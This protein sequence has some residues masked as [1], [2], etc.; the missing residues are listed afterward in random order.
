MGVNDRLLEKLMTTVD[1]LSKSIKTLEQKIEWLENQLSEKLDVVQNG[2][3]SVSE[4]VNSISSRK[5]NENTNA[6]GSNLNGEKSTASLPWA[7]IVKGLQ[8]MDQ[9]GAVDNNQVVQNMMEA[10]RRIA[11][12]DNVV[13]YGLQ[14]SDMDLPTQITTLYENLGLEKPSTE[15]IMT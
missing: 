10:K 2:V 9:N 11:I 13:V 3:S 4:K 6:R 1:T 12:A 14:E 8:P 5:E 7:H 15:K